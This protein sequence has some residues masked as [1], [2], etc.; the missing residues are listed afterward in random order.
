MKREVVLVFSSFYLNKGWNIFYMQLAASFLI[1]H[2]I[3]MVTI[4]D[5]CSLSCVMFF[6]RK[7]LIQS[8]VSSFAQVMFSTSHPLCFGLLEVCDGF[9]R[10][11]L[12]YAS[13][14]LSYCFS[15]CFG[16]FGP[17]YRPQFMFYINLLNIW[18]FR[19]FIH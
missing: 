19:L 5:N 7:H 14:V 8:L 9:S 2:Q 6:Q 18:H 16:K 3:G 12:S 13:E 11:S 1:F 4:M 17:F 15:L 10:L